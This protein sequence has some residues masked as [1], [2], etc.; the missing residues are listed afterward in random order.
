MSA[1]VE[2]PGVEWK[3]DD[4]M[5]SLVRKELYTAV[6]GDICDQMGLRQQFL[7]HQ[8]RPLGSGN[9]A[10]LAGRA[11]TVAEED[12]TEAPDTTSRG[13]RC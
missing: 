13:A 8:V 3:N 7:P 4:E 6:V 9:K 2:G 10:I 1:R 11:M 12:V 5:L